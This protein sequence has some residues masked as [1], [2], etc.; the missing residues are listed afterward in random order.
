MALNYDSIANTS[1]S[2]CY[3]LDCMDEEA[4]N[5][6]A[7]ALVEGYCV[8]LGCTDDNAPNYDAAANTDDDSCQYMGCTDAYAFNF[9][10][11]AN[12][13]D[14]SCYPVIEGCTD[15]LAHNYVAASGYVFSDVNTSVDSSCTYLGCTYDYMFNYDSTATT[16]DGSCVEFNYGCTDATAFNHNMDANTDDDSCYP[17]IYGCMDTLA[18]NYVNLSGDSQVD[19]NTAELDSCIYFGCINQTAFNYD[20]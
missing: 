13:D 10:V 20:S 6:N 12:T 8:Y 5:Y 11:L 9:D 3:Y 7:E 18:D 14:G 17:Y 15:E 16:D 1:D 19:V 2:T 4:D